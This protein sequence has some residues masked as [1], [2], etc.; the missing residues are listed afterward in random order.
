M[1]D[2][3]QDPDLML[4]HVE[5]GLDVIEKLDLNVAQTNVLYRLSSRSFGLASQ[6]WK[7]LGVHQFQSDPDH[8]RECRICGR[9]EEAHS[10]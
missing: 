4:H 3:E 10:G 8:P 2:P 1:P 6:K 7:E 9:R 5:A